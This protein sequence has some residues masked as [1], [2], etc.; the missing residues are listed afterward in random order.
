VQY[1]PLTPMTNFLL[2]MLDRVDIH[3]DSLG[4]STGKVDVMGA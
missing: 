4:D 1:K 3:A 2:G